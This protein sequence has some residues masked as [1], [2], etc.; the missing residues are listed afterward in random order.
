MKQNDFINRKPGVIGEGH[1][2]K[3]AVLIP[4][5]QRHDGIYVLFEKRSGNLRRQPGEIC[6]PGGK[7][8]QG[9]SLMDCAIRETMEELLVN[10]EQ[11]EIIGTG[12]QYISHFNLMIQPYIG[13]LNDYHGSFSSDEVEEVILVPL[14]FFLEQEPDAFRSRLVSELPEDFPYEWIPGGTGYPFAKGSYDILFYRYK[15][16]IIW[17]M[18]ALM[19]QSAVTLLVEY[20]IIKGGNN[21]EFRT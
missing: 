17:G 16:W 6:F 14:D 1:F 8:E 2:R 12:D 3:Y 19:T 4:L 11:I 10:R 15:D 21:N 9:E 5:V 13:I 18:T 20:Q 7:L